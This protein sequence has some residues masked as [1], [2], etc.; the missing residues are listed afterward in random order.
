MYVSRGEMARVQQPLERW[1]V[2]DFNEVTKLNLIWDYNTYVTILVSRGAG[3][4]YSK[5]LEHIR[6]WET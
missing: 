2:I 5:L 4:M 1:I 3:F 6:F